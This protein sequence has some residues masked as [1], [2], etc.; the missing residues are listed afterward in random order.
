MLRRL[1]EDVQAGGGWFFLVK[2][3]EGG[4]FGTACCTASSRASTPEAAIS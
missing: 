1:R 2:F 3:L 4:E